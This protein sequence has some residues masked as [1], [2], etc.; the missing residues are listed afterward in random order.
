LLRPQ[1]RFLPRCLHCVRMKFRSR[2]QSSSFGRTLIRGVIRWKRKSFGS[3]RMGRERFDTC[4]FWW[5]HFEV[6]LQE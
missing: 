1:L 6:H 5:E 3:G 2:S 4:D